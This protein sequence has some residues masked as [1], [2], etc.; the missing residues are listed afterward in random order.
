MGPWVDQVIDCEDRRSDPATDILHRLPEAAHRPGAGREVG[1][2]VWAPEDR[3]VNLCNRDH[4][5]DVKEIKVIPTQAEQVDRRE[6]SRATHVGIT[7]PR[8]ERACSGGNEVAANLDVLIRK[9]RDARTLVDRELL[10]A[11]AGW[12]LPRG[13]E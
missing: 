10:E 6:R 5:E 12:A 8:S 11:S 9:G 4:V 13:L 3:D 7:L 1:S 2:N